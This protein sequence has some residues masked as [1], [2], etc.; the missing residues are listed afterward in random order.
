MK[1]LI[2]ASIAC[3]FASFFVYASINAILHPPSKTLPMKE[4]KAAEAVFQKQNCEQSKVISD[5]TSSFQDQ[6][7]QVVP[8]TV[9][10][11][12]EFKLSISE[13]L[14]CDYDY[15]EGI[16]EAKERRAKQAQACPCDSDCLDGFLAKKP[17]QADGHCDTWCSE[18]SDLDCDYSKKYTQKTC[19]HC[20]YGCDAFGLCE[21]PNYYQESS[22]LL[23]PIQQ[24]LPLR[25]PA[26]LDTIIIIMGGC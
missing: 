4:T 7:F 8:K 17:C 22:L 16:C 23:K 20:I 6:F 1:I 15:Y 24:N 19:Y 11:N 2:F 21:H 18:G 3:I 9:E 12:E 13:L 26:G 14:K 25:H 5:I 10:F